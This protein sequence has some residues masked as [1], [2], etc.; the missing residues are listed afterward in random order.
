M[1]DSSPVYR[2]RNPQ[3]SAYYHC[4]EDSPCEMQP[5]C[6]FQGF[7][8]VNFETFEQVYEDPPATPMH[9]MS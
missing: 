2:P 3:G 9:D 5:C 4:V 1:P 7:H 8:R 6:P